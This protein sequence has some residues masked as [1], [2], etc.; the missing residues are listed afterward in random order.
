MKQQRNTY[1]SAMGK[2]D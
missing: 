1:I 2:L